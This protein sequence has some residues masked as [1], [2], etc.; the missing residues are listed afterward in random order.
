MNTHLQ[1]IQEIK[2]GCGYVRENEP[3]ICNE[4][5]LCLYCKSKLSGYLLAVKNELEE[6]T[7]KIIEIT[8][9]GEDYVNIRIGNK[10]FGEIT[11]PAPF[12]I[13]IKNQ[14]NRITDCKEA[15]KLGEEN[16]N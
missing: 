15:I 11:E 6:I 13:L 3:Y 5:H 12:N 7:K 9:E 16:D 8:H 4:N 10:E 2:K 1:N 14:Q